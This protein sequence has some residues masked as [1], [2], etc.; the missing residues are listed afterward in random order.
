MSSSS[1]KEPQADGSQVKDANLDQPSS[2]PSVMMGEE[3]KDKNTT[4]GQPAKKKRERKHRQGFYN[5]D[6]R[7]YGVQRAFGFWE[8]PGREGA[9]QDAAN[10]S[11][12]DWTSTSEWDSDAP[13]PPPQIKN[14]NLRDYNIPVN[15]KTPMKNLELEQFIL[16]ETK[17]ILITSCISWLRKHHRK[18]V[19]KEG[20]VDR[21]NGSLE[22]YHEMFKS[23]AEIQDNTLQL[24]DGET[25]ETFLTLL[26]KVRQIRHCVFRRGRCIDM[27]IIIVELMLQD[28]IRLTRMVGGQKSLSMLEK[29]RSR[30]AREIALNADV[31]VASERLKS[32]FKK[33]G[34]DLK[35]EIQV[36]AI[37]AQ[38][39]EL[40][41]AIE[42]KKRQLKIIDDQFAHEVKSGL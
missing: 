33:E 35:D 2:G 31:E 17:D 3:S 32:M 20:W 1:N 27:P 16:K 4:E 18:L 10:E 30:L 37:R 22:L 41:H 34:L 21:K 7:M 25:A 12:S 9:E 26:K 38:R 13:Y 39:V 24:V 28:A 29:F 40:G 6:R 8:A 23:S 19:A 42:Q 15:D 11:N 5:R 36:R 14:C